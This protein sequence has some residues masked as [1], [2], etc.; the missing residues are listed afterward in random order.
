MRMGERAA[1]GMR[2]GDFF[3][4]GVVPYG[5][6]EGGLPNRELGT[7]LWVSYVKRFS[8]LFQASVRPV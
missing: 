7:Y 5:R 3:G 6:G 2:M 8:Q 4:E 1:N